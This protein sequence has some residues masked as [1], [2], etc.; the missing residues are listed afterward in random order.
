MGNGTCQGKL[1]RGD[2]G[3]HVPP[4]GGLAQCRMNG[5]RNWDGSFP[6]PS[7]VFSPRGEQ[8]RTLACSIVY[9]AVR[10]IGGPIRSSRMWGQWRER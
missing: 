7:L 4:A 3:P 1:A 8:V 6:F 2:P 9:C 10:A 5:E